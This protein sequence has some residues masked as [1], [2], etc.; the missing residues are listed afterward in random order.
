MAGCCEHSNKTS[1]STK[2]KEFIDELTVSLLVRPSVRPSW[3]RAPSGTY[4][5][6]L[7]VHEIVV[8]FTMGLEHTTPEQDS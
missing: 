4:D 8:L 7:V 2:G 5:Q 1:V 6:N 3:C